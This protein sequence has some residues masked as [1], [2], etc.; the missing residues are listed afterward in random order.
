MVGWWRPLVL[1]DLPV[2]NSGHN[3][4]DVSLGLDG[5]IEHEGDKGRPG[6]Y[7]DI[8]VD[9]TVCSTEPER[10]HTCASMPSRQRAYF[11]HS[12]LGLLNLW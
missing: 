2:A 6:C 10:K 12:I 4:G 9:V 8:T 7:L 1:V 3:Q 5:E 11:Y